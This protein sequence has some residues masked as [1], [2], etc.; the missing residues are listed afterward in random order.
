MTRRIRSR[1]DVYLRGLGSGRLWGG[2]LSRGFTHY[3]A[4]EQVIN[5]LFRVADDLALFLA[6]RVIPKLPKPPRQESTE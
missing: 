4:Q 3:T 5:E 1:R 6:E 2:T